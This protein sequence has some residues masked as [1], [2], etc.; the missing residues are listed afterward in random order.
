MCALWDEPPFV[1]DPS[2][3]IPIG[4]FRV[5]ELD[6]YDHDEWGRGDFTSL[7]EA[8]ARAIELQA[9]RSHDFI[10][11]RIWNDQRLVIETFRTPE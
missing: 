2:E 3:G 9:D 4:K 8:R 10:V 1:R 11:H 6:T 7:E 5:T